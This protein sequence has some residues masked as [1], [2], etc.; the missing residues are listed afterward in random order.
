MNAALATDDVFRPLADPT[1]RAILDLLK[2]GER[3]AN[4]L[5]APFAMSQPAVSQH[6]RVLREAGLVTPTRDGR[7]QIYRLNP[8]PM[9]AAYDWIAHF[10]KFWNEKLDALG[11]YLD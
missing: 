10:V 2:E 11:R 3:S 8:E 7:R 1:T 5:A 4:D 9:R 6:L